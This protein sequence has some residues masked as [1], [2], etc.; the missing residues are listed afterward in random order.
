[1]KKM[2]KNLMFDGETFPLIDQDGFRYR[3]TK[4]GARIYMP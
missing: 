4:G 1:M 2:K 3:K